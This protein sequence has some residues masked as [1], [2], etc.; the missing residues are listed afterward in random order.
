[1]TYLTKQTVTKIYKISNSN[2]SEY[3]AEK[4]NFSFSQRGQ[5]SSC[6][7]QVGGRWRLDICLNRYFIPSSFTLSLREAST[8]HMTHFICLFVKK[9]FLRKS[10][11]QIDTNTLKGLT[12]WVL[13]FW[14]NLVSI[15]NQ[16]CWVQICNH[17][18]RITFLS[19][20]WIKKHESGLSMSD[21][22]D[23]ERVTM[24]FFSH[25]RI[26][27]SVCLFSRDKIEKKSMNRL[28]CST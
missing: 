3:Q 14:P 28:C 11:N 21:C 9:T 5:S 10:G 1:M 20:A 6:Y 2:N 15:V 19:S 26:S 7:C 23:Y 22:C 13:R 8:K 4:H 25:M 18:P 16:L 12:M 27:C 17:I 24:N